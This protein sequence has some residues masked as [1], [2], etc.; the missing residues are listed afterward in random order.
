MRS[1]WRDMSDEIR[2]TPGL[3]PK[4]G[5]AW[6][7]ARCWASVKTDPVRGLLLGH[8]ATAPDPEFIVLRHW[9]PRWKVRWFGA[10]RT[11]TEVLAVRDPAAETGW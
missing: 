4:I 7:W 9:P 3:A 2:S 1:A 5:E 11:W 8:C 6:S 10:P